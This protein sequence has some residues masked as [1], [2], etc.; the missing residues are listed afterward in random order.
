MVY[1]YHLNNKL[2]NKDKRK[3]Y[4]F[5]LAKK[6]VGEITLSYMMEAKLN[7]VLKIKPW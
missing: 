5:F 1:N 4:P 7:F 6:R 2:D 3:N